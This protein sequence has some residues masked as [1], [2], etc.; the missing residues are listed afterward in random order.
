MKAGRE[1]TW[2][3][4]GKLLTGLSTV[5]ALVLGAIQIRQTVGGPDL[6]VVVSEQ[7]YPMSPDL[8]KRLQE[9][10]PRGDL[11]GLIAAGE[12]AKDAPEKT[13]ETV[14]LRL[15]KP[16]DI[17]DVVMRDIGL[18]KKLFALEVINKSSSLAKEV[19][20]V[21]PGTG[22]ADVS[23][24]SYFDFSIPPVQWK[25]ELNVGTIRPRSTLHVLV[26]PSG[27]SS[28]DFYPLNAAV[29]HS[30]GGGTVRILRT[31]Y[32]WD[33]DLVAWFLDQ[34]WEIRYGSAGAGLLTVALGF[35][36]AWRRGHLVIRPRPP[37]ELTE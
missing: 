7:E 24:T 20:I 18:P 2:A 12:E 23:E 22:S 4:V 8:R 30:T 35:L 21:L 27:G 37:L 26:W 14:K 36:L 32:G 28:L 13:L 34:S 5:S 31:F 9:C 10:T 29:Y 15:S 25:G 17:N 33:A 11:N 19:R 1:Q 16:R 3:A 6:T